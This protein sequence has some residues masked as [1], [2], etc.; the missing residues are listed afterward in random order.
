MIRSESLDLLRRRFRRLVMFVLALAVLCAL[1]EG[2]KWFGQAVGGKVAGWRLPA[3][4]DN[5]SMPHVWDIL[6]RFAQPERRGSSHSILATVVRK[7]ASAFSNSLAA[8][9]ARVR[10]V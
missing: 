10:F 5:G 9:A 1:W 4:T 3:R 7:S 6:H 8:T 2:Y